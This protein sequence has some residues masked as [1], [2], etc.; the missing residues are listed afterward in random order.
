[1]LR[2]RKYKVVEQIL[3]DEREL[4]QHSRRSRFACAYAFRKKNTYCALVDSRQQQVE[5]EIA[6]DIAIDKKDDFHRSDLKVRSA[7]WVLP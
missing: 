5:R 3:L 1:L 2:E 6:L 4:P 7:R